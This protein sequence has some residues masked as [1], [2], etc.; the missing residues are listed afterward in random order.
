MAV[1]KIKDRQV[2]VNIEE[3][4]E[5]FTWENAKWKPDK[6]ICSSPFREDY[7]PSFFV[8]LDGEYAGVWGDSGT[9]DEEYK[10]GN[11]VKLLSLLK[12]EDYEDVAE[13]LLLKYDYEYNSE[14]KIDIKP[15]ELTNTEGYKIVDPSKYENKPLDDDYLVSRGIHPKIIELQSVFGTEDCIGIPWR[16]H[17]G[18]VLNIKYRHKERKD[19]WYTKSGTKVKHLVYGIDTVINRGITKAVV[20]EAEIDA[21]T[22]QSIGVYAIALGG[23][24]INDTQADKIIASGLTDIILGGDNDEVGREFNKKVRD[25]LEMYMTIHTINYSDFDDCKDVNDLGTRRL[26]KV[27]INKESLKISL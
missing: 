26:K 20:C 7:S 15:P 6:L 14:A 19:F 8:T 18:N 5:A 25:K 21:M 24:H 16:D 3:E 12:G 4:I 9:V 22:W 23:S 10:S 2:D 17:Q 27:R 13:Y 1:V 11:L